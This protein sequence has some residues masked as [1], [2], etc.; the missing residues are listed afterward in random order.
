MSLGTRALYDDP[1]ASLFK[2]NANALISLADRQSGFQC[3]SSLGNV[4]AGC[5]DAVQ[6]RPALP[7]RNVG[8]AAWIWQIMDDFLQ[9]RARP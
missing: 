7:R 3:P 9:A 4:Q 2:T 5:L 6:H 1:L 8:I